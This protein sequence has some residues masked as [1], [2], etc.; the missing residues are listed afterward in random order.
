MDKYYKCPTCNYEWSMAYKGTDLCK[1]P[2]GA[3][4]VWRSECAHCGHIPKLTKI[5]IGK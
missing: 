2:D 1:P 4:I 3:K 5:E